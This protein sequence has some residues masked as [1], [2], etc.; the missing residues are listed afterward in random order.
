MVI[1]L[2]LERPVAASVRPTVIGHRRA[3]LASAATTESEA[4]TEGEGE[5][6]GEMHAHTDMHS[7]SEAVGTT[8]TTMT[9]T[10]SFEGGADSTGMVLA[11]PIQLLGPNAPNASFIQYPL[12]ESVG[13]LS[14]HGQSVQS[15]ESSGAS[16]M[17][18]ESHGTAETHAASRAASRSIAHSRGSARTTGESEAFEPLYEDLPSTWHSLESERYRAGELIRAL[19]P[20]RAFVSWRGKM[21]CITVP[22]A[23]Y[24]S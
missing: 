17:S 12:S 7:H 23:K 3:H 11:P 6:I 13:Q 8:S 9:G 15:A 24:R 2:D 14:S 22:Q 5:T 19:P 16:H 1:P 21:A 4:V 18:A 20:G 10:G